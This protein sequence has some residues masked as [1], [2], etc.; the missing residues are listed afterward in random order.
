MSKIFSVKTI[1]V[2]VVIA[3]LTA[4]SSWL[5][6]SGRDKA[7]AVV[8]GEELT[9]EQVYQEM[10][11]SIGAQTKEALITKML[12]L[13]EGKENKVNVTAEEV[14]TELNELKEMW[15]V[16][17]DA[18]LEQL[19]AMQG[20][21]T[22]LETLKEQI[23]LWRTVHHILAP[24]I[25]LSDAEIQ[26][27]FNAHQDEFGEPEQVKARHILVATEDEAKSIL[28]DL[29]A[30]AD[31]AKL[32]KEKSTDP[33]SASAGGDLGFIKKGEMVPEFETA[34]FALA[35][36]ELSDIVKSEHGYH[37][38]QVVE[39]KAAVKPEFA[40]AKADVKATLT[41][42]KIEAKYQSWLQELQKAAKIEYPK[43]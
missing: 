33:G 10:Y 21:S 36:G 16:S 2:I 4:T 7:L 27:Y 24:T 43:A 42:Q 30:G 38:I 11:D 14:E 35:K 23:V 25:K 6:W 18:E 37:I 39:K 17:S 12:I 3:A 9:K 22:T 1:G 34:A 32:A 26:E 40:K 41:D 20:G 19:L 28:A 29:K 5:W 8:N 15:G 13:Q 31:F